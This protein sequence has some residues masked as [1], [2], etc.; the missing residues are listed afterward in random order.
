VGLTPAYDNAWGAVLSRLRNDDRRVLIETTSYGDVGDRIA[1][2]YKMDVY[3]G[4]KSQVTAGPLPNAGFITDENGEPRIAGATGLDVKPRYFYRDVGSG[5]RE[6]TN[7]KGV[8]RESR[9]M[10]KGLLAAYPDENVLMVSTTDDE[11]KAMVFVY[12]DR[13]PGRYL[14]A[15]A[16]EAGFRP[17]GGAAARRP[18]R[19]TRSLRRSEAH[20]HLWRELRRICCAAERHRGAR[21]VP[22]HL[23][24][25]EKLGDIPETRLG[26]GHVKTVLGTD[27]LHEPS[28][29]GMSRARSSRRDATR[30]RTRSR[31]ASPALL[32]PPPKRIASGSSNATIATANVPR[33]STASSVARARRGL[34]F[35]RASASAALIFWPV[36]RLT[37]LRMARLPTTSLTVGPL[38]WSKLMSPASPAAKCAPR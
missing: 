21:P 2:L 5:W 4:R 10:L 17:A 9:P 14:L 19:S 13:D 18:T 1:T 23:T 25:M 11:K 31:R 27:F 32:V 37:L 28:P 8:T 20:L 24:L 34:R 22:V 6:L 36:A 30:R 29:A 35:A 26:R 15:Q 12:S 7:L 16:G 38:S 3:S 33:Y